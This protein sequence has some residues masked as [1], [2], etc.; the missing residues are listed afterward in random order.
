MTVRAWGDAPQNRLSNGSWDKT[1]EV[2]EYFDQTS[3][4][5]GSEC[6][7]LPLCPVQEY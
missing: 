2:N 1:G 7:C 5:F 4:S 3:S 6:V